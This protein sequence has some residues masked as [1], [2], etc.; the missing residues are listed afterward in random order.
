MS[1]YLKLANSI[2]MWLVCIPPIVLL[3]VEA[4]LFFRKS[5]KTGLEM[6]LKKEQLNSA[7]VSAATATVGPS[8]VVLFSMI[9]LIISLGAPVA[10]IRLNYI[11]SIIYELGCAEATANVAGTTLGSPDMTVIIFGSALWVMSLCCLPYILGTVIITPQL[12]KVKGKIADKSSAILGV[13]SVAGALGV[14]SNLALDR[15]IPFE[16][17]GSV[18]AV[19]AGFAANAILMIYAGKSGK[20]WPRKFGL[21]ISMVVGMLVGCIFL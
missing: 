11:G 8:L 15:V 3:L 10:W 18:I 2:P 1:D 5:M 20:M 14:F 13:I 6:G 21:T 7:V 17:S 16:I 12:E 4:A 19:I 9:P